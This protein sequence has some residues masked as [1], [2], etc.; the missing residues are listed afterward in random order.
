MAWEKQDDIFAENG[1]E[2]GV[3]EQ[4]AEFGPGG[5]AGA[6]EEGVNLERGLKARHITMIGMFPLS[7]CCPVVP[8]KSGTM[9]VRSTNSYQP[10]VVLLELV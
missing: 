10:S 8:L 3:V 2:K 7:F 4:N 5:V 6:D 9:R 1:G